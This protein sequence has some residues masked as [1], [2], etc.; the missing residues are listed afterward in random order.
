[1]KKNDE[2]EGLEVHAFQGEQYR[3]LMSY[4]SWRVAMLNHGPK[5]AAPT[6]LERHRNTDEAFVLLDGVATL[7]VGESAA[8]VAMEKFKVYNV[9]RG[10]W[11]NIETAPGA[12]CLVVE[13]DDTDAS[14]TDY[15]EI[16]R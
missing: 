3:P 2:I 5:F 4:C 1:M 7:L 15:R 14:N 9:R 6:C 8:R 16:A 12:K 11:H 13:N 10:T